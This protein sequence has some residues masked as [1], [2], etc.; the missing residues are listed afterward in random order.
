MKVTVII[1]TYNRYELLRRAIFS[2]LKQ[3][4]R[5][6][7]IIVVDDGSSDN[8]S[9]ITQD[10]P[11]IKYFYQNNSGVSAARNLGIKKATNEWL[12]FLDS[13]DEWHKEKLAKQVVFH[14]TNAT[15]LMSYKA[16]KWVRDGIEVK[17]PKKYRK[18]GEDIFSENLSYCNIAPS[19]VMLHRSLLDDVGLFDETLRVC[20]DYDLWLR[21][22][23][24]HRVGL[25][26]EKL[27]TKYAGHDAQLGFAKDLDSV[28]MSV[29]Q[30]LLKRSE[31]K[32]KNALIEAEL[33]T[34]S[35]RVK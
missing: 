2:L 22:L 1:P 23:C 8:T 5:V 6:D 26:N 12:A 20:E 32:E 33:L 15:L 16:E 7:E 18:I 19:C 13:D 29:L 11:Q 24:G 4:Y 27:I 25:V 9:N 28:R 14:Q 34:K 17:I 35:A 30:K 3:S 31:C 10:F 21:V